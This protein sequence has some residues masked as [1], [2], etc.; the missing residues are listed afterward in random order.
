MRRSNAVTYFEIPV[1][2]MERAINFYKIVFDFK[3]EREII[4]GYEMGFIHFDDNL[5]GIAG[6]LAKGDIYRPTKSGV[7]LY[8]HTN[9]IDFTLQKAI[10]LGTEILLPKIVNSNLG[11]AIAEIS[12]S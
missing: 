3:I 10:G 7:I 5:E 2:N 1:I 9:D 8:F 6:S 4:D 12:D 11:F